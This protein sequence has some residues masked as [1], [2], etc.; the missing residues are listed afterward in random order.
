MPTGGIE[1]TR[2]IKTEYVVTRKSRKYFAGLSVT[3]TF[4]GHV[5]QFLLP[6]AWQAYLVKCGEEINSTFCKINNKNLEA[7]CYL[8][9]LLS[10]S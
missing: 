7:T 2:L 9:V 8:L 10:I 4:L 6:I 5:T 3:Q 1:A